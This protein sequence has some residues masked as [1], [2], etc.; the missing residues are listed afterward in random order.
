GTTWTNLGLSLLG[1]TAISSVCFRN[2][3]LGFIAGDSG[4]IYR[5]SDGGNNWATEQIAAAKYTFHSVNFLND[6]IGFATIDT[7]AVLA[8]TDAGLSWAWLP[9][10]TNHQEIVNRQFK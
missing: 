2:A 6:R 7:E 4:R 1:R 3:S 5:T 8:S 9:I 10:P